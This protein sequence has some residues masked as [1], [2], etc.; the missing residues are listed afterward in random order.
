MAGGLVDRRS[1]AGDAGVVERLVS[2]AD[3][4]GIAADL[5]VGQAGLSERRLR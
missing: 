5:A 1:D 4:V 3:E 2:T